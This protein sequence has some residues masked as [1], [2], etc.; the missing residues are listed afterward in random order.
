MSR[1]NVQQVE[2]FASD[3]RQNFGRE[4]LTRKNRAEL[5][6]SP[7]LLREKSSCK[8]TPYGEAE[9]TGVYVRVKRN[10]YGEVDGENQQFLSTR[11]PAFLLSVESSDTKG[12][13]VIAKE[14]IED[15]RLIMRYLS[16]VTDVDPKNAH[17]FKL[18][19]NGEQVYIDG[20]GEACG[21]S[22]FIASSMS[23]NAD[24]WCR[25]WKARLE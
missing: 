24:A 1:C 12:R 9:G 10:S 11:T 21:T 20:G 3:P 22:A 23:P 19:V 15:G 2:I 6:E 5:H 13:Y 4:K 7:C 17:T 18:V 16:V 14:P 8:T 25:R